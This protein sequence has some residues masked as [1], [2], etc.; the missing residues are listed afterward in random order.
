MKKI[1][2]NS[3]L[4]LILLAAGLAGITQEATL[5]RPTYRKPELVPVSDAPLQS[6]FVVNIHPNGPV[7][8]AHEIYQLNGA[9]PSTTY[10]VMLMVYPLD[11]TAWGPSYDD[12]DLSTGNEQDWQWES[13]CCVYA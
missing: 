1:F 9:A 5:T 4:A 2:I 10:Q 3:I 8:F 12:P 7:I 13:R 11:S 6:G